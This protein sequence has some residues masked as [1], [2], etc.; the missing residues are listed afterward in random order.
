[1]IPSQR[2]NEMASRK[3]AQQRVLR[4]MQEQSWAGFDRERTPTNGGSSARKEVTWD[5]KPRQLISRRIVH[6]DAIAHSAMCLGRNLAQICDQP[7][8]RV[9]V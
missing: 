3:L 7:P 1:M 4:I 5:G 2:R 9:N 8:T 6:S